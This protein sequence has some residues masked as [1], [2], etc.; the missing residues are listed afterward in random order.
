M[1]HVAEVKTA[2][3]NRFFRHSFS[4]IDGGANGMT[5][6]KVAEPLT[7]DLNSVEGSK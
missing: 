1:A 6:H 7:N 2:I 5:K 4:P 3:N